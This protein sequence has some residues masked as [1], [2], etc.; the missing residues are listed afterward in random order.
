MLTLFVITSFHL[1]SGS[2]GNLN[3]PRAVG[4]YFF[5]IRGTFLIRCITVYNILDF[6]YR[7]IR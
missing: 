5:H 6:L 7:N 1:F 3:V 4:Y 2:A